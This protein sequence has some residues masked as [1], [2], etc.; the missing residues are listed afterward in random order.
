M[1]YTLDFRPVVDGLP[2]L[3]WGCVGTLALALGGMTLAI[4]IGV[5][6]VMLRDGHFKPLRWLVIVFVELT[7]NTPFLPSALMCSASTI[8]GSVN[9]R[10]NTP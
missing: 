1:N 5:G 6:G 7:R 2:T 4:V 10:L 8:E 3:L 9:V